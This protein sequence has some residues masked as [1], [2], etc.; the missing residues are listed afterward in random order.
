[1]IASTKFCFV[2]MRLAIDVR[3]AETRRR[4]RCVMLIVEQQ[5]FVVRPAIGLTRQG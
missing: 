2:A 5:H 3:K 1:M 4:G